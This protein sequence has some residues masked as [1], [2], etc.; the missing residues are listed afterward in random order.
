VPQHQFLRASKPKPHSRMAR[1]V[2]LSLLNSYCNVPWSRTKWLKTEPVAL[3]WATDGLDAEQKPI[4]R[5]FRSKPLSLVEFERQLEERREFDHEAFGLFEPKC[6]WLDDSI[7]VSPNFQSSDGSGTALTIVTPLPFGEAFPMKPAIDRE[8]TICSSLQPVVQREIANRWHRLLQTSADFAQDD[9]MGDLRYL[10][11][12]CVSLID[13]T[14][15]QLRTKAEFSP[16][17]DWRPELTKLGPRQNR[18]LHDKI[19]WVYAITGRHLPDIAEELRALKTIR[20]L[21]NHT[22]HF[23]PPCFGFAL[24][25]VSVWLNCVPTIARL[26]WILRTHV[27]A[28]LS[29][30]LIRLLLLPEVVFVPRHPDKPRVPLSDSVGYRSTTWPIGYSFD[31]SHS[32]SRA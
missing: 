5:S 12:D 28:S 13:M 29:L 17:S 15:L 4:R 19:A 27:G 30:P 31:D 14:L 11:S 6:P 22:Q 1:E 10:F 25:E 24:E 18:R 8:G 26:A 7:T 20:E 2:A 23:D 16:L 21:R 9:W 3:D 32:T